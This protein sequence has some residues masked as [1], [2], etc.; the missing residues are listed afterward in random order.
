M[1]IGL[2]GDTHIP[3]SGPLLPARIADL[4]Q[5]LDIILH[6]GDI[7][8]LSVLEE[9]QETYTLTFAVWGESDSSE[10]RHYL[11]EKRVVRFGRRRVGMIHGHQYGG[12]LSA[13]WSRLRRLL[14]GGAVSDALADYLLEQFADEDVHAIVF[15]HTHQ[16]LVKMY[17]GVLLFNPGAALP[18]G[19]AGS[20]VGILDVTGRSIAGKIVPL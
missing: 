16:P 9:L 12:T 6:V 4:F 13:L 17:K 18:G 10:I 20:S 8:Q 7:C 5:G 2:L 11:E 19:D 14:T 1:K 15:G 3:E